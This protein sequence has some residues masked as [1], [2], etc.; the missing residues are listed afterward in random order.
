MTNEFD[1]A[2]PKLETGRVVIQASAGTGKTYSLAV[3]AIRH[4]A[5]NDLSPDQILIVTFTNAA[6][7]ELREKTREQA[8]ETLHHLR[9]KNQQQHWM[10]SMLASEESRLSAIRNLDRF[11]SH[12]DQ[13]TISTIHGFCQIVLRRIG[14]NSPA[15]KHYVVQNN[16]DE[17]IDQVITDLLS[18]K[19]SKESG[20][21]AGNWHKKSTV[22]ATADEVKSSLSRLRNAVKRVMSNPRAIVLPA[23]PPSD[24]ASDVNT[25]TKDWEK[26]STEQ[27]MIIAREVKTIIAE[28]HRRSYEAGIITYDD[29]VR[30]VAESLT[31]DDENAIN[32]ANLLA[33]QYKLIMV[34]EFQDTDAA[35]WSIFSRIHEAKPQETTLIT[36]GDPKQAIYRF[37]GADVQVYINANRDIKQ[38]YEI[39]TNYRSDERLLIALETLLKNRT[40]ADGNDVTFKHVKAADKNKLGAV[41]TTSPS[42]PMN[43][44]GAPLEIRYLA[45]NDDLG[46]EMGKDEKGNDKWK[47]N[48]DGYT[49]D[50][51]I[52]RDVANHVV[53]LLQHG[54]IPD[55]DSDPP[56][57]SKAIKPNDIAILVNGH[58]D[59]ETVVRYLNESKVPAVRFKTD[60][61]FGSQAAMHLLMLLGSLANPGKPQFVRAYALSWFGDATEEELAVAKEEEIAV[62]QRECA[63]NAELLRSRGISAL[64]LSFRNKSEF[65]QRVLGKQNGEQDGERNITDLD[66]LVEILASTPHL[67][68]KAGA[69]EFYDTLLELVEG[70]DDQNEAFQRRIEGD[71]VAVKVMTIHSSKGLQFPIVF[72]PTLINK[73]P[74]KNNNPKM[75]SYLLPDAS[76]S[77]R[78]ID[79]AS[80]YKSAEEWVLEP[81]VEKFDKAKREEL[82]KADVLFDSKRLLYVALTRA[83]HKVILYWSA[84]G[85]HD[86]NTKTALAEFLASHLGGAE[87]MIPR[88]KAPLTALMKTIADASGGTISAIHLP[89][90]PASKLTWS[91]TIQHAKATTS[92]AQFMRTGPLSTFGYSRWSYS[93][94]SRL[95]SDD[96]EDQNTVDVSG[97][98]DESNAPQQTPLLIDKIHIPKEA[99]TSSMTLY[100]IGGSMSFGTVVHEILDSINPASAT[101]NEELA[102]EVERHFRNSHSPEDQSKIVEGL[103]TA[104][105]APLGD[106]FAGNTLFTLGTSHRLS[107]LEFDFHLPQSSTGAFSLNRI[108]DLMLEHGQLQGRLLS[109]AQ[110][111]ANSNSPGVIAGFMNGSIDAVFRVTPESTPVYIVADY[112][113]NRLRNSDN[114]EINPLVL[115]H[116]DNLVGP[117]VEDDYILQAMVYSVALHRYLQWR[118]PGYDPDIHL[119]GAAYLFLRGMTGFRTD[120]SIP[121]PFGVYHW[122]PATALILALDALFAGSST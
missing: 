50:R 21:L 64:F 68:Q 33:D 37:R 25:L 75:F 12:F 48:N 31:N 30:L 76:S 42:P 115:Y 109:Y 16:I 47:N 14:L 45:N 108:G 17:I 6:T 70:S 9:N 72:L 89:L 73:P 60:S 8:K 55:K 52:W 113:T 13:A 51:I 15:P 1:L 122:R 71:K 92:A 43:I 57:S 22:P 114:T 110:A 91:P 87:P 88:L 61:V 120:E 85:A 39:G 83:E 5:E 18:S 84:T 46:A 121:R 4:I 65:L 40:F 101:L 99:A 67:M 93:K 79:V 24:W 10:A 100:S 111:I 49:V 107:E 106:T 81:T 7:A 38:T 2:A 86:G 96:Q 32:L 116:P 56:Y 74:D 90:K 117:M 105:H 36:V 118:Q 28:V 103:T 19:L 58:N 112:K 20:F 44:P 119:G 34:D 77:Q 27:A 94:L 66:H 69:D 63:K 54:S 97:S 41:T 53:E 80:G 104:I 59:A 11:L 62:W 102:V 78:V 82:F 3:L 23:L 29:M 35:Q 98:T 95:H 26:K